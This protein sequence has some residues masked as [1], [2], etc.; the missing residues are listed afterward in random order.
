MADDKT[1]Q[2]DKKDD[3]NKK[4]HC[5][6][7]THCES[8]FPPCFLACVLTA[9]IISIAFAL[10]FTIIFNYELRHKYGQKFSGQ[11]EAS[12]IDRSDDKIVNLE[13]GALIDFFESGET[14]FVFVS[15]DECIRCYSFNEK[16]YAIA[17]EKDIIKD[18]VHYN[19]P[20]NNDPSV[21]DDYAK[22]ITLDEEQAPVLL[23]V[24]DGKIYDRLDEV[25]GTAGLDAFLEKYM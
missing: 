1:R 18:I 19:Y 13:S 9:A 22:K 21:Y 11:Y 10:S 12:I 15:S 7:C 4:A 17:S 3:C 6:K 2:N 25:N 20:A 16:L 14:G 8:L 5:S 23:Y 24:R